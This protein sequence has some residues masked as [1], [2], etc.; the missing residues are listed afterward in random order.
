MFWIM[1]TNG[2]HSRVSI[3]TLNRYP[4]SIPL[5]ETLDWHLNQYSIDTLSTSRLTLDR[6]SIDILVD[7]W[8][9]FDQCTWIGQHS[10]NYQLTVDHVSIK[11]WMCIDRDVNQ[12]QIKMSI[13]GINVGYQSN[14]RPRVPLVHTIPCFIAHTS[15]RLFSTTNYTGLERTE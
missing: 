13:K 7:S 5:I 12:V 4:W 6:H 9:I 1:W 2:I 15:S 10:D 11:C 14:T 8:L 3:D